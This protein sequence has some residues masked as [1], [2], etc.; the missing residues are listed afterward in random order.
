MTSPQQ[1]ALKITT[2]TKHTK[3]YARSHTEFDVAQNQRSGV[4]K[5]TRW[6]SYIVPFKSYKAARLLLDSMKY[7]L[8]FVLAKIQTHYWFSLENVWQVSVFGWLLIYHFKHAAGKFWKNIKSCLRPA[9]STSP[10]AVYNSHFWV[11]VLGKE[12]L[13]PHTKPLKFLVAPL[14]LKSRESPEGVEISLCSATACR[15]FIWGRVVTY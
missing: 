6:P 7:F 9:L 1:S 4:A 11:D 5:S 14:G 15:F 13:L 12:L 10:P 3:S 2:I 8:S